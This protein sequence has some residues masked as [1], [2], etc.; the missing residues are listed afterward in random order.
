MNRN[1]TFGEDGE[2]V[3]NFSV[4]LF[5][6]PEYNHDDMITLQENEKYQSG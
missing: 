4:L 6:F 3:L 1:Q 5:Y 2:L